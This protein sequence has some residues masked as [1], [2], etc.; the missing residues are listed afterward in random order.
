MLTKIKN[1]KFSTTLALSRNKYAH[2]TVTMHST[3]LKF[4]GCKS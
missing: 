4:S 2:P 3:V 1:N